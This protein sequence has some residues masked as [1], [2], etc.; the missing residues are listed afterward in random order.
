[1]T[2]K[3]FISLYR[4]GQLELR[5]KFQRKYVWKVPARSLLVNTVLQNLPMPIVILRDKPGVSFEP[6]FEVVDGQQRLTT[7]LA[8]ADPT[9]FEAEMFELTKADIRLFGAATFGELA[10]SMKQA[11]LNYE[12]SVHSL[13]STTGDGV[14][15]DIF[16]RLNATGSRLTGQELRNSEFSGAYRQYS[17]RLSSALYAFWTKWGIFRD[18][19][20]NR[21]EDLE[22]IADLTIYMLYGV[23]AANQTKFTKL[24]SDF[25]DQFPEEEAC[26]QR[27]L[28]TID[29]IDELLSSTIHSS[30][31]CKKSWIYP[32]FCSMYEIK[33]PKTENGEFVGQQELTPAQKAAIAEIAIELRDKTAPE[34]ILKSARTTNVDQ[35]KER[36]KFIKDRISDAANL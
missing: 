23:S 14:V 17:V 9:S 2:V 6:K 7:L 18:A 13:P 5:P 19:E 11:F 32:L 31:F 22:F 20:F 3:T 12:L 24:Y 29:W 33:Y 1:M 25:D 8:F 16:T 34:N 15:L 26:E 30:V 28:S 27:L 10:D 36:V 35:R 4:Q 21:M